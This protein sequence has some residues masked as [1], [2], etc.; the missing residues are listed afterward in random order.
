MHGEIKLKQGNNAQNFAPKFAI[1]EYM[2][3]NQIKKGE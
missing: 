2:W 1:Y 3:L